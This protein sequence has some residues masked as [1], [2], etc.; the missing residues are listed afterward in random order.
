MVLWW[1]IVVVEGSRRAGAC[2]VRF[3]IKQR[4]NKAPQLVFF[5]SQSDTR[6]LFILISCQSSAHSSSHLFVHISNPCANIQTLLLSKRT[7]HIAPPLPSLMIVIYPCHKSDS[8]AFTT[9]AINNLNVILRDKKEIIPARSHLSC[10]R[11]NYL[12]GLFRCCIHPSTIQPSIK[13]PS[14]HIFETS[15]L[16]RPCSRCSTNISAVLLYVD[17]GRSSDREEENPLRRMSTGGLLVRKVGSIAL[18]YITRSSLRTL[19]LL[20]FFCFVVSV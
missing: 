11:F 14:I 7:L 9:L 18:P 6:T 19:L 17:V 15:T 12:F 13:Q 4:S 1:G 10:E 5:L 16:P 2:T 3:T 20:L 8:F